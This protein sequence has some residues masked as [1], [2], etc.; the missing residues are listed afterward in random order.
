M[1]IIMQD[2]L[3]GNVRV[4]EVL[5]SHLVDGETTAYQTKELH[6]HLYN[7]DPVYFKD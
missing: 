7:T 3:T 1:K 5:D 4:F 6:E 2:S